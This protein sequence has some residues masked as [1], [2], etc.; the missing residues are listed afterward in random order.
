MTTPT[1]PP[2]D[3]HP[4]ATARLWAAVNAAPELDPDCR[5]GKH[6]SCIGGPCECPC[7]APSGDVIDGL[8]PHCDSDPCTV[9]CLTAAH[10]PDTLEHL[11]DDYETLGQV[12]NADL[13]GE[14]YR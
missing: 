4:A 1:D 14:Y 10:S 6:T 13:T 12:A 11:A 5:D 2:A 9:D 8:C 3:L 7:H